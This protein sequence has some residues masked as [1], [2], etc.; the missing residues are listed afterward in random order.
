MRGQ[1]HA[2]ERAEGGAVQRRLNAD[3]VRRQ[4]RQMVPHRAWPPRQ[5]LD[6]PP[7]TPFF[8][9]AVVRSSGVESKDH[10]SLHQPL[11]P[12]L[13]PSPTLSHYL[14][15]HTILFI[16]FF[17]SSTW[18]MK[19]LS[20]WTDSSSCSSLYHDYHFELIHHSW[21][22][23]SDRREHPNIIPLFQVNYKVSQSSVSLK[24]F[25]KP[26]E[27]GD[28]IRVTTISWF[29]E[30][31]WIVSLIS[32]SMILIE[33][34]IEFLIEFSWIFSLISWLNIWLNFHEFS[35]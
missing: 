34:L 21:T 17:S 30:F 29:L 8:A 24:G 20:S 11:S 10:F 15:F 2:A 28:N 9:A 12:T 13:I 3:A 32:W 23:S 14:S 26:S 31:S 5:R 4:D 1:V 33:Y 27:T 18:P 25:L 7:L 19:N 16:P 35:L 6:L 22:D